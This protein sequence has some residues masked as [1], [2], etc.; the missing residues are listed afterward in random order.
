[1]L[2]MHRHY[3]FIFSIGSACSCTEA[4]R[5]AKLQFSSFPFDWITVRDRPGDIRHKVDAICDDFRNWFNKED[6]AYAGTKDWHLKDFYRNMRTGIVFNHEFPKGIPFEVS[7]PSVR[8]RY[9][10]RI[11]RLFRCIGSAKS[12]LMVR[13]DRP[14]QE[15]PA[16]VD[17]CIYAKTRLSEKF[18]GVNFDVLFMTCESGRS[19]E[20]RIETSSPNG[21]LR[22]SFDYRSRAADAQSYTPDMRRIISLLRERFTVGDY[23]TRAE[24][25][26]ER[27]RR[28][29]AKYAKFGAKNAFQYAIRRLQFGFRSARTG[30]KVALAF[31]RRKDYERIVPIGI[32]GEP[33]FHLRR[34]GVSVESPFDQAVF[35][36][37]DHLIRTLRDPASLLSGPMSFEPV[38]RMWRCETTG[39]LLRGG[40][41]WAKPGSPPPVGSALDRDE[42]ALRE[43][44]TRMMA[45]FPL[46]RP[47]TLFVLS[48][49]NK[50]ARSAE[51][52]EK[53]R[54]LEKILGGDLLVVCTRAQFKRMPSGERRFFRSV[55]S[56][57]RHDLGPVSP[58]EDDRL[59]WKAIFTEFRITGV[60]GWRNC[61]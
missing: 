60:N 20:D 41:N 58:L 18:P 43:K 22:I 45:H 21:L 28:R 55:R 36:D 8:E 4:L 40:F 12:V 39:V 52:D 7:F 1:M 56:F 2:F 59:G 29:S 9:D 46:N 16:T 35:E 15:F 31:L 11:R 17:D 48:L 24:R 6:F 14:D 38:S 51:L 42:A 27:M 47:H 50:D 23:R 54:Q 26:A 44:T 3:D 10:R 49:H 13:I 61:T 37:L 33:A 32:D 5:G 57:V 25:N 34:S 53:L 30:G 19:Y